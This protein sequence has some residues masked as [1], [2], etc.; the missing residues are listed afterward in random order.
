[1]IGQEGDTAGKA[2]MGAGDAT[3]ILVARTRSGSIDLVPGEVY[4]AAPDVAWAG[5]QDLHRRALGQSDGFSIDAVGDLTEQQALEAYEGSLGSILGQLSIT[6]PSFSASVLDSLNQYGYE[7][8]SLDGLEAPFISTIFGVQESGLDTQVLDDAMGLWDELGGLPSQLGGGA[9]STPLLD[10]AAH[11]VTNAGR[12]ALDEIFGSSG[13]GARS[14]AGFDRLAQLFDRPIQDGSS[15][16][17]AARTGG[18]GSGSGF[19]AGF[20]G[21]VGAAV[22]L[23]APKV[24]AAIELGAAI[25]GAVKSATHDDAHAAPA[26]PTDATGRAPAGSGHPVQRS[27]PSSAPTIQII[28]NVTVNVNVH[29]GPPG[30]GR[31]HLPSGEEVPFEDWSQPP[32]PWKGLRTVTAID[33]SIGAGAGLDALVSEVGEDTVLVANLPQFAG[34]GELVTAGILDSLLGESRHRSDLALR[35]R[36]YRALDWGPAD[37]ERIA[38][39]EAVERMLFEIAAA[40]RRDPTVATKAAPDAFDAARDAMDYL[41]SIGAI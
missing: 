17:G 15:T 38:H 23:V 28:L 33:A 21:V 9:G 36:S 16:P 3:A 7:H 2:T 40:P 5:L 27:A 8:K 20:L 31:D 37:T 35:T 34:T 25:I 41:E 11:K 13:A 10:A 6:S 39:R 29:S 12:E 32:N 24:G 1:V 26:H 18:G 19:W 14:S 30:S 22:S 4:T